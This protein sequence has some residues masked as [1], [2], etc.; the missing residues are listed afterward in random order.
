MPVKRATRASAA[1]EAVAAPAKASPA[2]RTK[3][4]APAA[5][6]AAAAAAPS[7]SASASSS[8][9]L[10][11]GDACPDVSLANDEGVSVSLR[12][13]VS[14]APAIFFVYPR[15]NTPGCTK[16]ACGFRDEFADVRAAGYQV[17]GLST[18]KPK[19][20]AS[21]RAKY[22]LPYNLLCD[23]ESKVLKPLGMRHGGSGSG[24]TR[25]H[26]IVDKGG[27]LAVIAVGVSPLDSVAQAVAYAKAHPAK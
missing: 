12:S 17:F 6:A 21:W 9:R 1:A 4:A 23:V 26:F 10:S 15:A 5:A 27:K 11:V 20:Q 14:S 16:Q 2:K 24:T 13:L 3:A 19:S 8:T 22:S 25:S 18:D 7:A